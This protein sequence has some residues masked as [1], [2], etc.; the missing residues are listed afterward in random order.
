MHKEITI[1]EDTDPVVCLKEIIGMSK[2]LSYI[3]NQH[4]VFSKD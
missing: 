2:H 1:F 3:K 4:K